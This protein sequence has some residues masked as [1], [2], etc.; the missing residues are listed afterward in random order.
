MSDFLNNLYSNDNFT[1]YII[2]AIIILAIIFVL[3]VI[4]GKKDKKLEET[5][6]LEAINQNTFKEEPVE[7]VKLEVEEKPVEVN[8]TITED[9]KFKASP[10][11][12]KEDIHEEKP[13]P[14][15]QFE[16][17]DVVP[18]VSITK[19]EPI[20]LQE[21]VKPI[22]I[23]EVPKTNLNTDIIR[24]VPDEEPVLTEPKNTTEYT[25]NPSVIPTDVNEEINSI[26]EVKIPE[27]DFDEL[28]ASLDEQYKP[29]TEVSSNETTEKP[30]L[31]NTQVFS[32]V[33]VSDDKEDKSDHFAFEDDV[34]LPQLKEEKTTTPEPVIKPID[35]DSISGESYNL[36]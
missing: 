34:E 27:F 6:R 33:F 21:E 17:D 9:T 11:D 2:L 14:E 28:E 16:K 8:N 19:E 23:N 18:I 20:S 1:M 3:V 15:V 13:M 31:N 24:L 30:N 5:K 10:I 12:I 32:S 22:V 25:F 29:K 36:K 4:L 35:F 26:P 7:P